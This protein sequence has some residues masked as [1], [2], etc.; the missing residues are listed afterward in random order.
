M[1]KPILSALA[2]LLAA[3]LYACS[4]VT[5]TSVTDDLLPVS[6]V[7]VDIR[8]SWDEFASALEVHGGFGVPADKGTG[9]LA[10][11]YRGLLDAR[12]LA[13]WA[14]FG[15]DELITDSVGTLV[16]DTLAVP[17]NAR[18]VVRFDTATSRPAGPVTIS[19]HRL[20]TEWD[21]R[22]ASWTHAVDSAG[23]RRPWTE[24]GA[25][26]AIRAG[27]AVWSRLDGDS[28]VLPVDTAAVRAWADSLGS[29]RGLRLDIE[30]TDERIEVRDVQL[31]YDL[32]P[33]VRRDTVFARVVVPEALTFIYT[34]VPGPPESGLRVG[35]V[36]AW[37]SVIHM[38]LPLVLNGPAEL[39]AAFG[40]PFELTAESVNHASLVLR[41]KPSEPAAFH[42][43]DTVNVDVRPVLAPERLPRAP[44]GGQI[45]GALG[46]ALAPFAFTNSIE[47][48]IPVT[49]FVRAQLEEPEEGQLAATHALA[50]LQLREPASI[51]FAS[52]A[53]P[54]EPGEPQ[55]RLILTA[56]P[57]VELP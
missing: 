14:R 35:G 5:P 54:G 12:T 6:P 1:K 37:R 55:L 41:A 53:G 2:L 17:I 47:V 39:C 26:P 24:E 16:H 36:P 25:G 18:L 50:L 23:D 10:N 31:R 21:E 44:L 43:T 8:L 11:D 13:R 40:C 48:S 4:E 38:D 20:A 15:L 56:I 32:K 42:P 51:A 52:F 29:E 19:A 45:A 9:T 30:S 7:T 27:Q 22:T 34:P 57:L 33:S 28:L 3:G 49:S 46:R